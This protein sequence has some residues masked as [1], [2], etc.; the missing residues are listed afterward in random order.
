M[1][2]DRG[3]SEMLHQTVEE[4]RRAALES[5]VPVPAAAYPV[6]D[7]AAFLRIFLQHLIGRLD[8]I[9]KIR[10]HGNGDVAVIHRIHQPCQKRIL[11]AAVPAEAQAA[12]NRIRLMQIPYHFP[13]TV[14]R[15][16]VHKKD[17]AVRTDGPCLRQLLIF[18]QKALRCLRKDLFF[19]VA[20]N[21]II[22]NRYF[23]GFAPFAKRAFGIGPEASVQCLFSVMPVAG[24]EP[25]R[26]LRRGILS[27][28]C[29]PIPPH[30]QKTL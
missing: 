7:V 12:E 3:G 11:M 9:L 30:R 20:W 17:A 15:T 28:L 6:D 10:I 14:G 1:V 8:I 2:A 23:H 18:M 13:G 21:D 25:A 22:Q 27:P 29:L 24:L 5:R 16:V 26:F 4:H 19:V